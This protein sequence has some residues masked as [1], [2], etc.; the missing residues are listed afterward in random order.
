MKKVELLCPAGNRK[1]LEMAI[2]NGADAVY[3]AGKRFGARK[4][5]NNFSDDEII[6]AIKYAHLYGVKVYVTM[7]TLVKDNEVKEFLNFVEL[8]HKN[9]VDAILM[10]DLGMINLV[11]NIYPNLEIHASTQLHNHNNEGLKF[12][13]DLGI[14]RVVLA[15]ELSIN[16]I[17]NLNVDI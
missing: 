9:G 8:L 6:D 12:L 14:K 3:L 13:R 16:E 2:H 4:F 1:M 15:R 11:R 5:S 7:N 10:Q 17:S